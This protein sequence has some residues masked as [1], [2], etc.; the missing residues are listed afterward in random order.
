[1]YTEDRVYKLAHLTKLVKRIPK[2]WELYMPGTRHVWLE[3]G[4]IQ[5]LASSQRRKAGGG[6]KVQQYWEWLE[7]HWV[8]IGPRGRDVTACKSLRFC[9]CGLTQ[10]MVSLFVPFVLK[11]EV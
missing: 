5:S 9:A 11:L 6:E 7:E 3:G 10:A 4:R 1:M 2:C 8:A